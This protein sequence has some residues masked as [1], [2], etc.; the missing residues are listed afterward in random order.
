MMVKLPPELAEIVDHLQAVDSDERRK[1]VYELERFPVDLVSN[2]L[3][4]A[5]KDNN[6]GVRDAAS[7]VIGRFPASQIASALVPLLGSERIE[8]RNLAAAILTRFGKEISH[9]LVETINDA[10]EDVRKFA[11]DILGQI[12]DE[13]S[14]S[15]L[16]YL[17]ENDIVDNVVISAMEALGKIGS[18][19]ALPTLYRMFEQRPEFRAEVAESLGL[20]GDPESAAFLEKHLSLN[21]PTIAFGIIDALGN[22]GESRSLKLLRNCFFWFEGELR[23]QTVKAILKIGLKSQINVLDKQSAIFWNS[24]A[25]LLGCHD[26]EVEDLLI[27]QIKNF[28]TRDI[29]TM[30]WQLTEIASPTMLLTLLESGKGKLEFFKLNCHLCYHRDENVAYNAIAALGFYD[31]Q[32]IIP[33]LRE[34]ISKVQGYPLL[35]T[36]KIIAE[37][38]L[39]EFFPEIK[40]LSSSEDL[41]VQ[42]AAEEL[43]A[44]FEKLEK[45]Y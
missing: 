33:V 20:I 44:Y 10:N 14:V 6:R 13:K 12:K 40:M 16:C 21:D 28:P 9:V 37:K 41:D 43:I 36:I 30:V 35:A 31:T 25:N 38:Q 2:H 26:S 3:I 42:T 32:K 11:V 24:I 5:L 29:L 17:A 18:R 22:I 8:V 34:I 39:K 4:N 27:Y 15:V 45:N 1:A 7:E 23:H 19:Q